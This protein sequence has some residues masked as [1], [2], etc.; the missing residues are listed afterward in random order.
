[1]ETLNTQCDEAF[2]HRDWLVTCPVCSP[3]PAPRNHLKDKQVY[4]AELMD[5]IAKGV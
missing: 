2:F 5:G 3:T 1:M 4:S